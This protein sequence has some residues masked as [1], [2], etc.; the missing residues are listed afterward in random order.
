[1]RTDYNTRTQNIAPFT[2][3][4]ALVADTVP[5]RL[6]STDG[7][8]ASTPAFTPAAST[9]YFPDGMDV[10]NEYAVFPE[11][12]SPY[13]FMQCDTQHKERQRQCS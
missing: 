5:M 13:Y 1:M 12:D 4:P 3:E 2:I 8:L 11:G 10:L 6:A 9:Q 7:S